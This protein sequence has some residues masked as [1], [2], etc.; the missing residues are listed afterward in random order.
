MEVAQKLI[1]TRR[2]TFL[3]SALAALIAG[4]LILVYVD[5]YRSSVE[6]SGTPVT[7]LIA[8]QDIPKGTSGT[9][10][11]QKGLFTAATIRESQLLEGAFSDPSSLRARVTTREIFANAQ[12]TAGDFAAEDTSIA[13]SLTDRQRVIA[14]PIDAAHG[15]IG[16]IEAGDRVDVFA[17][18]NVTP[19]GA[20]G[21]P[22][23]GG[24]SRAVL[25]RIM[26]NVQVADV[27][28]KAGNAVSSGSNT[29][30][31]KVTDEQ[32]AK[33]AFAS[34]NGKLWF[35]LRPSTGAKAS[36][37]SLVTAETLLLGVPPVAVLHAFGGRR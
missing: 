20:D 34:D 22:V 16:K 31:L 11:A 35:V 6:S 2:G 5:R 10:I 8:R 23:N 13:A 24:Q 14:I 33:L 15:L 19:V 21:T 27:G 12:L 1:S 7:V 4:A 29:V 9:V 25:R 3:I 28:T 17:G 26:G 37:P 30:A 18:F 36:P 32:A